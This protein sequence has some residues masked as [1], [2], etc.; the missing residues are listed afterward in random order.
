MEP[1]AFETPRRQVDHAVGQTLSERHEQGNAPIRRCREERLDDRFVDG[2][3]R[4]ADRLQVK[5][6]LG[7]GIDLQETTPL[8]AK[9]PADVRGDH[10]NSRNVQADDPNG[11]AGEVSRFRVNLRG[12]VLACRSGIRMGDRA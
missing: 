9:R 5:E 12:H 6:K 10:V 7:K 2:V 8:L 1:V 11:V 3:R 4:D